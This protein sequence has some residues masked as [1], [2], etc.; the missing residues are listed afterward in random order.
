[1]EIIKY[2]IKCVSLPGNFTNNEHQY[3]REM[4]S[5]KEKQQTNIRTHQLNIT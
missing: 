4:S 1:M 2:I 5:T 3:R